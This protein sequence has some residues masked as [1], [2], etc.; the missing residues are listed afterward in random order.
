[1]S[2]VDP[3]SPAH[4]VISLE[5]SQDTVLPPP[6]AVESRP[7]TG[8]IQRSTSASDVWSTNRS[9]VLSLSFDRTIFFRFRI[10]RTV[11]IRQ[12][13]EIQ[14][15]GLLNEPEL[16]LPVSIRRASDHLADER[17]SIEQASKLLNTQPFI[18]E[19]LA[20]FALL[21]IRGR[22]EKFAEQIGGAEIN[23]SSQWTDRRS[24]PAVLHDAR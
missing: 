23:S 2:T 14:L 21:D 13:A 15:E 18:I 3:V 17:I 11:S 6:L 22:E 9:V 7:R 20:E 5:E 8:P 10:P 19:R 16:S 24:K 4:S 12:R 1:M